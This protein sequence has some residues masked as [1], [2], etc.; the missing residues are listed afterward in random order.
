MRAKSLLLTGLTGVL[1]ALQGSAFAQTRQELLQQLGDPDSFGH[2]A[3]YMGLVSSGLVLLRPSCEGEE[4]GP[5]DRCIV[6]NPGNELTEFNLPDIGRITFPAGSTVS[7]IYTIISP[8]LNYQFLNAGGAPVPNARFAFAPYFTLESDALADPALINPVTGAPFGGRLD[9]TFAGRTVDRSLAAGERA[10]EAL[11][12][13]RAGIGGI[14]TAVLRENYG[15]SAQVIGRIFRG[16][17]TLRVGMRG[18]VRQVSD[19]FLFFSSR[20]MGD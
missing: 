15:L 8:N 5:D 10:R 20:F 4:L 3:K 2:N 12:Y 7:L 9:L 19:A 11:N 18:N 13:T 14:S 16:Q 17:I 1:L 6:L